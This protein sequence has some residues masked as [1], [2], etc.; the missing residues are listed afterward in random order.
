MEKK[1]IWSI[2]SID[3][4]EMIRF[5][6]DRV[7]GETPMHGHEFMEIEYIEKGSLVQTINGK[8]YY[9]VEGDFFVFYKGDVHGYIASEQ[10]EIV[11]LV[12]YSELY[13][14]T[15]WQDFYLKDKGKLK[16][17]VRLEKDERERLVTIF[18]LMEEEAKTKRENY[19]FVLRQF[20]HIIIAYLFR[21][22]KSDESVFNKQ[23]SEIMSY[24]DD[25]ISE[26]TV[27]ALAEKFGYQA[28]SFSKVFK[29]HL[30]IT[31]IEYI[32]RRK[33]IA[34]IKRL[35]QTNESVE[36]IALS[37][38]FYNKTHFY[39]LFKRYTNHLPSE[40]RSSDKKNANYVMN[41]LYNV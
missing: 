21:S 28:N 35:L 9:G 2:D 27:S 11:N 24:V 5:I 26:V 16:H 19:V 14:E 33:I 1:T 25:N 37:L 10:S 31:P 6:R 3:E 15:F 40:I 34:A 39:N 20:L 29:K 36:A 7:S 41:D 17:M 13:D 8:E 38:N 18:N 32:N 22:G 12:F 23:I 30:G 4:R